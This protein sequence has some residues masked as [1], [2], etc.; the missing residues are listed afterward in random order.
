MEMN[1]NLPAAR[2]FAALA[3]LLAG[4]GHQAAGLPLRIEISHVVG[5]APL[6]LGETYR[7]AAGEP[8]SAERLRYYLSNFRLRRG[9]GAW[10][11]NP[12]QAGSSRGYFLVDEADAASRRFAIGPLPP[13]SYSGIEFL[14][15]VDA[16]RNGAGA[17]TGTLD[18]ARGM[19]WTWNTGY[20]FFLFEGRSPQSAD[21]EHALTWHVGGAG[22]AARR[23][24]LQLS[25]PLEVTAEQGA[26]VHLHA[27][28]ARLFDGVHALRPAELPS[29]MEPTSSAAVADNSAGL[30]RIDHLHR[31]P[32]S[33]LAAGS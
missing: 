28:L 7:N 1:N 22:V 21:A 12:Q 16:Q 14:L 2:A 31:L 8:W 10:F 13:A 18:P 11:V 33:E 29:A 20:I 27:D 23:V 17:Q 25:A 5:D 19:F 30:F 15:G 4:C 26:E 9:D 32:R 3:L 6:R 24:Y